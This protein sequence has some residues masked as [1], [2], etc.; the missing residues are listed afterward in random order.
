[1][2]LS[3][4][5]KNS[6][7][8]DVTSSKT[9]STGSSDET[10]ADAAVVSSPDHTV[11]GAG[12]EATNDG[13]KMNLQS[14]ESAPIPGDAVTDKTLT[15]EKDDENDD[16]DAIQIKVEDEPI[17]D[18]ERVQLEKVVRQRDGAISALEKARAEKQ[19]QLAALEAELEKERLVQM[20]EALMHKIDSERIK[21][22]TNNAEERLK[23]LET[24]MQDKAAIHEYANLIKGVA[25]KAGVD[26]QYV[27][28]L[29][30]QLQKAVA[31]M[32][33]TTEQ[34]NALEANSYEVVDALT[35][36]IAE[37]VEDRCRTELELRKQLDVLET[38]KRDIQ[39]EYEDRIRDNLKTLHALKV[40]ATSKTTID[41]LEVELEETETRLEELLRIQEK[42]QKTIDQLNKSLATQEVG[43]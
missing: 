34:M 28:K 17:E 11:S 4:F 38:Q 5:R 43:M 26:A 22:Q 9:A 27:T 7:D 21:R 36:E 19:Q 29:Q 8:G 15:T 33:A 24:D 30:S 1:M 3:R 20:K 40:K 12:A 6:K 2:F 23:C 13:T 25:P 16:D 37:L 14:P 10:G 39:S 31:K 35:V 42:Q 32:E 18:P 41:E